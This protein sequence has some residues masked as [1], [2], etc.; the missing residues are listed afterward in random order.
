MEIKTGVV[1]HKGKE[2]KYEVDENGYIWLTA[3]EFGKI[4]IN[5]KKPLSQDDIIL[6]KIREMLISGG[7]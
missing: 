3:D 2:F 5:Q 6:E 7:Y 1:K 4:K